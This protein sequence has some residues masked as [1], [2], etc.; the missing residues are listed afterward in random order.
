MPGQRQ[1]T[2]NSAIPP[3]SGREDIRR[4]LGYP[5]GWALRW[6][7][8]AVFATFALFLAIAWLVKYP[9]VIHARVVIVTE[10]PP[11]RVIARNSG[12]I[13]LL[14]AEDGQPVAAGQAIAVLENPAVWED[15]LRLKTLITGLDS[16]SRPEGMLAATLPEGLRL[17][18]MQNA[19]AAYQQAVHS[20]QFFESQQGTY[21]R[22]ASLEQQARYLE[23]LNTALQQ[24][25]QTL[26]READIAK[27]SLER[28]QELFATGAVSEEG[29]E[30]S[31][32]SY[33]QYR[34]QLE[35]LRP[36][37][38]NNKLRSEQ[39]RSEI[40]SLSQGRSSDSTQKWLACRELFSRLK[41]ELASWEQGYLASS[42][43]AGRLSMAQVWSPQ[44]YVQAGTPIATIVPGT[45]AG[46][47]VG[48]AALPIFN[49]GKIKPGMRANI[50]LDGYPYQEYGV[51]RGQVKH[52][53]PVPEQNTYLL[54]LTLPDSLTTSYNY[55][56][57]FSQEL[58]G[59]A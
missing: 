41:S 33:L 36:Q 45:E 17:G 43:I 48:K 16:I 40:I 29:L 47:L 2:G 42:P 5:P 58:A 12:K 26:S 3:N 49:S 51:V 35:G 46:A 19:Y 24:Q 44:Q 15:V 52:I 8:T 30:Q 7:I 1:Y 57:P 14:L 37:L 13:S 6:G 4:I 11:V 54:E 38:L 50:R 31:E 18:E 56:I 23:E 27:R 39:A 20:F 9:D 28:S 25:E 32:A 21:A 55:S 10:Q 59:Q 22:I 53:S 34:R